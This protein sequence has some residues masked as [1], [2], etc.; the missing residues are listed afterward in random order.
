M[1][2]SVGSDVGE[3]KIPAYKEKYKGPPRVHKVAPSVVYNR[4]LRINVIP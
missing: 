3:G 1:P 4:T 2:G